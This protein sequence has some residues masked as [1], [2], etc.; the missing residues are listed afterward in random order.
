MLRAGAC[1]ALVGDKHDCGNCISQRK[2]SKNRA[3]CSVHR[4]AKGA[5]SAA[6]SAASTEFK[7]P[8]CQWLATATA[9]HQT[10]G[11]GQQAEPPRI[12]SFQL[13]TS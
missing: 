1:V 11:R 9:A 6:F 13:S 3:L 12:V 5:A 10:N 8:V 4:K 2:S 7:P